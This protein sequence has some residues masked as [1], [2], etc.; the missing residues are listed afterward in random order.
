MDVEISTVPQSSPQVLHA[1]SI[2]TLTVIHFVASHVKSGVSTPPLHKGFQQRFRLALASDL[3]G[4]IKPFQC[5]LEV[6]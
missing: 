4:K 6:N 1:A 3:S 5:L 2:R